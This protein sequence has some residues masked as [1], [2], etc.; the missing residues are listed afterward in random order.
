[1]T[2]EGVAA[3]IAAR[4][5][6][7]KLRRY[8]GTARTVWYEVEIPAVMRFYRPNELVEGIQQGD[9]E[10]R[11]AALAVT[12]PLWGSAPPAKGHEVIIGTKATTVQSVAPEMLGERV[13]QYVM[14]VRG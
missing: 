2:P 14:Q 5:R 4:G 3:F 8:T 11:I 12:A 1:V 9:R 10:I 7:V 6:P 13:A